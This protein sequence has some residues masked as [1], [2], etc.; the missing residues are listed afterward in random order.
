MLGSF[1]MDQLCGEG[2][3]EVDLYKVIDDAWE[4]LELGVKGHDFNDFKKWL[5][6]WKRPDD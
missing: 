6:N 5:D 4:R 1:I 3:D 2:T